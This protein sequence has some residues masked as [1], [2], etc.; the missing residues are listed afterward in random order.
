MDNILIT[1][2]TPTYNRGYI[3][4]KLYKSLKAQSSFNFEWLVIDDGSSDNTEDL[5][6]TWCK[7]DNKFNIRYYKF[8]N[9]GKPR[10]INKGVELAKGKYF[11]MVDSDDY[12][13]EDAIK[14]LEIWIKEVDEVEDIVAV[15]AARAFPNMKYIKGIEPNIDESIGYLDATNI[16]RSKYN[17]DADMCEAYKIKILKNFPFEVWN[18]EKFS[19]EEIV[20][21]EM[22]LSGYKVRWHKDIIYICDYLEDGLTR[23]NWNLLKNNPMGYAMLYN[24]KLKFTKGFKDR[25]NY[26]CQHIALSIIGKECSYIFKS[27][28]KLLTLIALPFG[29]ILSLRRKR[30]FAN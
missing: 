28:A 18:G 7:S 10:A 13:L 16:D 26:A 9:G 6:N 2:F 24:H 20:L 8:E 1:V 4:E 30:Q 23:G 21:N 25:F 17:L 11:F 29:Y 5:F 12:L 27:N 14:K 19:P 15:G 22:S 3:I